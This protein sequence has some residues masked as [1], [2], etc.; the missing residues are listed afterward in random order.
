MD[1]PGLIERYRNLGIDDIIGHEKFKLISIVHHSTK[2]EGSTLTE[3]EAQVL[4]SEGLTP[5][6]KPLHDS[7]MVTDHYAALLFTLTSAREKRPVT[8]NLIR[9]INALVVKNTGK[10]YKTIFGTIDSSTG[11]FRKGNVLAGVSYFPN[12]DK[13]EPLTNE[14]AARIN[15]L[16]KNAVSVSDQI[17]LS[18]DAHFNLVSIHPFY[19]GNGRTSRLLMNYI[20]AYYNLPSAIVHSDAKTEYIEAL[21]ATREKDDIN[22]FR[23]FMAAEYAKLLENEIKKFEEIAQP[24]KGK[25]FNL[26]F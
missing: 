17:N 5:K 10:I 12:Y 15:E 23:D 14:M 24:K 8:S 7:L 22:I 6:G 25:G 19:D 11:E 9:E 2:I 21:I 13:V 1:L 18:F 4:I 20:Q 3:V 26:M 16:M